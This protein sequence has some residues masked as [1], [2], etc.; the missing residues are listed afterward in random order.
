MFR[1]KR[2]IRISKGRVFQHIPANTRTIL[3]GLYDISCIV[4]LINMCTP[5]IPQYLRVCVVRCYQDDHLFHQETQFM[6]QQ[7]SL[8]VLWINFQV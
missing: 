1:E 8:A 5:Y 3:I 6:E 7:D 2:G 4:W